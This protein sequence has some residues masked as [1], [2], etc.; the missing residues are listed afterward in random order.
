MTGSSTKGHLR[1]CHRRCYVNDFVRNQTWQLT[2]EVE[3]PRTRKEVMPCNQTWPELLGLPRLH[4]WMV[5][6]FLRV[7]ADSWQAEKED[8]PWPS[9]VVW[10]E[11]DVLRMMTTEER[12]KGSVRS[13]AES[14][15][16][17]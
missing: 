16:L 3:S 7:T 9:W 17:G 5:R 12:E 14:G 6:S 15:V 2:G 11:A 1:L 13:D 8:R 10:R 4:H